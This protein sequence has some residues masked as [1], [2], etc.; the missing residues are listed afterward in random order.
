MSKHRELKPM[1][2]LLVLL[3]ITTTLAACNGDT[4]PGIGFYSSAYRIGTWVNADRSD[5]LEFIDNAHLTRR[6]SFYTD[7]YLYTI[8]KNSIHIRLPN[9][10]DETQH[11]ILE[12]EGNLVKLGNMYITTGMSDNS[13]EFFKVE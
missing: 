6:G 8:Y 2:R 7:E 12:A 5:T 10:E 3:S 1:K 9:T 11:T 4:D 13:G